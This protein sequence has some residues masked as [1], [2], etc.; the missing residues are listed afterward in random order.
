MPLAVPPPP[1]DKDKCP[2][3]P[4]KKRFSTEREARESA[5]RSARSRETLLGKNYKGHV[6][7]DRLY[8]YYCKGCGDWH[9]THLPQ[10][11]V[12]GNEE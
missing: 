7:R 2:R 4:Y 11:F 5:K 3:Q 12:N 1:P 9:L 6:V 10:R 8:P